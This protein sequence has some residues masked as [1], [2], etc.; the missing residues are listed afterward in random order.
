MLNDILYQLMA[1]MHLLFLLLFSLI[2]FFLFWDISRKQGILL[3]LHYSGE[4]KQA[5]KHGNTAPTMF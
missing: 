1:L 5:K 3:E 4:T 2:S